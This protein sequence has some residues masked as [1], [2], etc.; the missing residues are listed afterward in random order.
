M[1]IC[2]RLSSLFLEVFVSHWVAIF[3]TGIVNRRTMFLSFYLIGLVC[4]SDNCMY[5]FL[6]LLTGIKVI[7]I[8]PIQAVTE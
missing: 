3:A 2:C 4:V 7:S 1:V 5:N 6:P 8:L